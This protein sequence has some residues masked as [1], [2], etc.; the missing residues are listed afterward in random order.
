[1]EITVRIPDDEA[2]G[3]GQAWNH[4]P[5]VS[6]VD[7]EGAQSAI[8]ARFDHEVEESLVRLARRASSTATAPSREEA[9]AVV[10]K[11]LADEETAVSAA[12]TQAESDMRAK[13][14][15]ERTGLVR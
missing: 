1:M 5:D 15:A 3:L 4:N 14:A 11:A 12:Q 6:V 8:Q 10:E 2:I 9:R 13:V 7:T